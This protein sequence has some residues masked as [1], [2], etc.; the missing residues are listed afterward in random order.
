MHTVFGVCHQCPGN[1]SLGQSDEELNGYLMAR[2]RKILIKL[3]T[4]KNIFSQGLRL[5][6]VGIKM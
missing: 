5:L 2:K 3:Q 1:N 4:L 6:Y